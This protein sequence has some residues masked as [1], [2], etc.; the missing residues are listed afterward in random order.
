MT[1]DHADVGAQV[2]IK[3]IP[4]PQAATV[5]LRMGISAG[6]VLKLAA[7]G[8]PGRYGNCLGPRHLS[9][10]PRGIATRLNQTNEWKA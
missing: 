8:E 7:G 4:D 3:D 6:E 5:A 2:L 1:L 10:H 9:G